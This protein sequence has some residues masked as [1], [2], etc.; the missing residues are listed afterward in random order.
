M[1]CGSEPV[2]RDPAS[3]KP[4]PGPALHALI[5]QAFEQLA[6][7]V[8]EEAVE[9]FSAALAVEP[10]QL[11]ALRGRGLAHAHLKRWSLA[12][13]DFHAVTELAPDDVDSRIDWANSLAMDTQ[14]YEAL[15]IFEYV[16][17][18]WPKNVRAHIELGRMH[19]RVGA[20]TKGREQLQR[21]LT[22]RPT[23][24]QRQLITDILQEQDHLDRK[25][26]YRPDFEALRKQRQPSPMSGWISRA[27]RALAQRF[28]R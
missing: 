5:D 6:E 12:L 18:R 15:T 9:T 13:A 4:E 21:A 1:R 20:V 7:G 11:R 17:D 28:S 16:L 3:C 24:A 19:F 2:N 25:R 8:Y 14:V 26:A 22:C 23:R 10:Q 27:W